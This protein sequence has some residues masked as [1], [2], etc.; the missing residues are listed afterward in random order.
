MPIENIAEKEEILKSGIALGGVDSLFGTVINVLME[1]SPWP[2]ALRREYCKKD[3][4]VDK[5]K[6]NAE[7]LLLDINNNYSGIPIA[8]EYKKIISERLAT[9]EELARPYRN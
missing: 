6:K 4:I 3:S 7:K 9:L 2:I 8:E 5:T 1:N